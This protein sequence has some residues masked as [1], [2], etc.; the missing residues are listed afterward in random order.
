MSSMT[1]I[2]IMDT[3][4]LPD[5]EELYLEAD[6]QRP[7]K[8]IYLSPPAGGSTTTTRSTT[9]FLYRQSSSHRLKPS[10]IVFYA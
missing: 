10:V 6:R 3:I 4:G 7:F 9:I 2:K 5:I 1:I 8:G